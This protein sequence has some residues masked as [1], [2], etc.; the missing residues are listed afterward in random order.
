MLLQDDFE[1][2][3]VDD[4]DRVALVCGPVRHSY[5]DLAERAGGVAMA[6]RGQGV[7]RGDR[8]ALF[9]DNGVEFVAGLLAALRL[10]AVFMPINPSTKKDKLAYMLDDARATALLTQESLAHVWRPAVAASPTV[11]SVFAVGRAD[12]AADGASG[13]PAPDPAD[14]TTTAADAGSIDQDLAAIIYTSGSTG[15]PKGVM[16]THLNMISAGRSV[17]AYLGLRGDDVILCALPL[18]F[19]YGLYQVL[20][21][22]RVGA[23]VVVERNFSFPVTA[24]ESMARERVTIF[25]GVPTMFAM[26]TTL[27]SLASYDLRSLRMITNTAAALSETQIRRLRGLFPGAAL[28]SMYG[29][30]ECQRV[31]YLPP[32]QLD[33]RPTSVGRGMPNEEVWLVDDEG[34]RLPDGATGELVIRGSHV[35]RGY[36]EKPEETAERLRPGPNP[37]ELVLYSGDLFRTDAEGW[38]YF[39]ARRDDIIK[40][41]GEKVSPREVENAISALDG[42]LEV[43]VIGVPDDVL[44]EAIK[45]FITVV[46]GS[47]LSERDVIRHCLAHLEHF[48]APGSVEFVESLPMTGTGKI[49]RSGLA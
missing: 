2:W 36:W 46:P 41:R 38:L 16:L 5:A 49:S 4:P 31:S 9:L 18:S 24:L 30:T 12:G 47:R 27:P 43:A 13:W 32:E 25:P 11:T 37:G 21:A 45:A 22:F 14:A 48:M 28:F 3:V 1:R 7:R 35:M 6:L 33:E 8:V 17:S 40:S 15:L 42:V 39:I 19:D 34:R 10:G 29:L 44:G 26:L 23:S 20:M